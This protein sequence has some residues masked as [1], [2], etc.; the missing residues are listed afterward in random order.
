VILVGL[1]AYTVSPWPG[2]L[3]FRRAFA[4]SSVTEPRTMAHMKSEVTVHRNLNYQSAYARH[5]YDLYVPKQLDGADRIPVVVWVHGGG[6]IAGDKTGVST[7]ATMLASEGY[8]VAAMNYDYAPDAQYPTPVIQVGEMITQIYAV[9]AHYDLDADR[10]IIGGDSAGAQIA[11]QF[12]AIQTTP[13]YAKEAGIATVPMQKPLE[14]ALLFCGPYDVA[15]L[16][17]IGDSWIAQQFVRTVGWSYLGSKDW[18]NSKAA[19][20]ASVVDHISAQFPPSYIVDGN[21]FSFPKHAR[22]LIH[23]LRDQGVSVSSSLYPNDPDLPH[24]FQFD[25]SHPQSY[26]VWKQTLKFLHEQSR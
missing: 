21:Y 19:R 4:S 5:E 17:N 20:M 10:V 1:V 2:A 24:E 13:G 11:A 7:Y 18:Q 23:S 14:A 22:A 12:A 6:F 3:L 8:A 25:F 9:A 16:G 26:E 15:Q